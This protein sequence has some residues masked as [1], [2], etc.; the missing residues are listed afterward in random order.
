MSQKRSNE[1]LVA[2]RFLRSK[3]GDGAYRFRVE[4]TYHVKHTGCRSVRILGCNQGYAN[5]GKAARHA[6]KVARKAGW[7]RMTFPIL[8][9]GTHVG[10]A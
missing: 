3:H 4:A 2:I 5:V 6:R 9:N 1:S 7:N 10:H 8:E